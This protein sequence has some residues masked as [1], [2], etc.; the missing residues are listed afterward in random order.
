[1]HVEGT[2]VPVV[3]DYIDRGITKAEDENATVCII[4][5]DT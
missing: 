4:E 3:A 5:L 2:I 1:M